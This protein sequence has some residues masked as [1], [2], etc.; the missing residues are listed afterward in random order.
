LRR[1]A[2]VVAAAAA[3]A[4]D[5]SSPS[6]GGDPDVALCVAEVNRYR[7]MADV[8]PVLETLPLDVYAT[9]GARLDGRTHILDEHFRDGA[10]GG[11]ALAEIELGW[12]PLAADG[13]VD[14]VIRQG[15]AGI[16]AQ[17]PGSQDVV[18]LTGN[19]GFMGCGIFA[20]AGE[21]TVTVDFR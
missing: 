8:A 18:R 1:I 12:L 14:T 6:P 11:L 5:A 7:A 3:A 13:S 21:V 16:W 17:G 10:G 9:D 2:F 15:L 20:S 19:Y 4:C